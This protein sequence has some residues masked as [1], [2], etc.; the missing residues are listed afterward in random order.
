MGVGIGLIS[1]R[2]A[3]SGGLPNFG[4]RARKEKKIT[5]AAARQQKH[6]LQDKN[7]HKSKI[8][9]L[10]FNNAKQLVDNSHQRRRRTLNLLSATDAL[11]LAIAQAPNRSTKGDLT[12]LHW[13]SQPAAPSWLKRLLPCISPALL[14]EHQLFAPLTTV[15]R[16]CTVP[17]KPDEV[18]NSTVSSLH[19]RLLLQGGLFGAIHLP[20]LTT[21]PRSNTQSCPALR[22]KRLRLSILLGA[23]PHSRR[24]T[25]F[26]HTLDESAKSAKIRLQNTSSTRGL[27]GHFHA[28]SR[29]HDPHSRRQHNRTQSR[30]NDVL[31]PK[32]WSRSLVR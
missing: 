26:S 32:S 4:C 8:A 10:F 13:P 17:I 16:L 27:F 11:T 29:L 20:T 7:T 30:L 14:P 31:S 12:F 15:P 21:D 25:A 1:T 2:H 5:A 24:S 6:N 19:C 18:L 28:Q 9:I 23:W 22:S 3:P